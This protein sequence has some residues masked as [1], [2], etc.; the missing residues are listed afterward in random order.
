MSTDLSQMSV[1]ELNALRKRV[2]KS[3]KIRAS[4]E[5]K[6]VQR[7]NEEK[8]RSAMKRIRE[9]VS[10]YGL[11]VGE[12]ISKGTR[13]RRGEGPRV[14]LPKSPAK[15]RNPLNEEQTWTGKGRKPG[16]LVD[17][18]QQGRNLEEFAI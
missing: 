4:D 18:L 1:G 12:V 10:T 3:L 2:E 14:A 13:R 11:D 16:W 7:E 5:H 8:R 17:L 6:A 15:Y 9:L